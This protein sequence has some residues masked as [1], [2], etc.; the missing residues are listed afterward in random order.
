VS[1]DHGGRSGSRRGCGSGTVQKVKGK[2]QVSKPTAAD[3][4]AGHHRLT[5]STTRRTSQQIALTQLASRH[6]VAG[7]L[8]FVMHEKDEIE[9]FEREGQKKTPFLACNEL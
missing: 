7:L 2:C 5:I 6:V 4:A 8:F 9:K 3:E 1:G